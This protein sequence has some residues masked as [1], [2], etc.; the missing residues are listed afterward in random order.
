MGNSIID[1]AMEK[2]DIL[3]RNVEKMQ[4]D[5][6]KGLRG[7]R[8]IPTKSYLFQLT[9]R[10]NLYCKMCHFCFKEY[11]N[12]TYENNPPRNLSL[13]EYKALLLKNLPETEDGKRVSGERVEFIY[14]EAETFLNPDTYEICKFTKQVYPNSIVRLTSNGTVPPPHPDIVKYIDKILFS[15]DGCTRE[16]FEKIRTPAKFDHMLRT[17]HSWDEAAEKYNPDIEFVIT[18]VVSTDNIDEMPDMVD[19]VLQFKHFKE[20]IMVPIII[21]DELVELSAKYQGIDDIEAMKLEH[22]DPK[23]GKK[24]FQKLIK[25]AE[26][27]GIK[28]FVPGT[29]RDMFKVDEESGLFARKS[30]QAG[31]QIQTAPESPDALWKYNSLC[32]SLD[33][34]F[35]VYSL[36]HKCVFPCCGMPISNRLELVERYGLDMDAGFDEIYNSK[37]YWQMRKDL[38]DGKLLDLCK[39]CPR[40]YDMFNHLSHTPTWEE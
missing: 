21:S 2:N 28:L 18:T 37:G 20:L 19:F 6:E 34:G 27:H 9:N 32:T 23:R 15:I 7:E 10:C 1:R 11:E 35:L 39:G 3:R 4:E 5:I 38:L 24:I 12:K 40:G 22:V 26:K 33:D 31:A 16:T 13:E 17:L 36:D 30:R 8:T 25:R 29:I 14:S